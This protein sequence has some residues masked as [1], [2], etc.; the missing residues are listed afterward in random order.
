[1]DRQK[2]VCNLVE[3]YKKMSKKALL[4]E[5]MELNIPCR[6]CMNTRQELEKAIKNSI[7]KDNKIILGVDSPICMKY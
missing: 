5:A 1:M 3:G 7:I 2:C 4:E 6:K